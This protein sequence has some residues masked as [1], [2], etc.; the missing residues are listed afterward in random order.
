MKHELGYIVVGARGHFGNYI[1]SEL[2]AKGNTVLGVDAA[3]SENGPDDIALC[4]FSSSSSAR[5]YFD[6]E[7]DG[8]ETGQFVIVLAQGR[9]HNEAALRIEGS[10]LVTHNEDSWDDVITSNLKTTFVGATEFARMCRKRRKP[11]LVIAFSSISAGG[12]PGQIAYS[13]AKGGIES[14]IKS[15]ARELGPS[16][17]RAVSIAPGY[18]DTPSTRKH[19]TESRIEKIS[20]QTPA[21][22]LGRPGEILSTI[23]WIAAT[24]F[25]SGTTIEVTGGLTL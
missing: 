22:R 20:Q 1:L 3:P 11:G 21:R 18:I 12:A 10:Q 15:F 4:D 19:V 17:I 14:M 23:E 9:I 24:E 6:E 25:V 2:R 8:L 7:C 13:A 5:R 16:G